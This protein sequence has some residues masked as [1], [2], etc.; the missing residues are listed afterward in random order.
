MRIAKG[1]YEWLDALPPSS[2]TS[3]LSS[4]SASLSMS[5]SH[6]HL[7]D[8]ASTFT[9]PASAPATARQK[10]QNRDVSKITEDL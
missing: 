3:L 4:D 5:T 2:P 6:S 8:E 10:L 7:I 9:D 1:Q